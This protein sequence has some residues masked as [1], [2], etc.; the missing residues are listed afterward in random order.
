MART[1]G[2]EVLINEIHD[3]DTIYGF[4]DQGIGMW[5]FGAA[6]NGWGL[7]LS[8]VSCLELSMPGGIETRDYVRSLYVVGQ[9]Y[10]FE[11]LRWDKYSNR[12]DV[13]IVLPGRGQLLNDHLISQH[14]AVPWN[15]VGKPPYPEW[16]RK[17]LT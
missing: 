10:P 4:I 17:E 5:N 13:N 16:P 12:L 6:K 11:S 2:M 9:K 15:G 1:F 8:G 14:W 7:R 3:G